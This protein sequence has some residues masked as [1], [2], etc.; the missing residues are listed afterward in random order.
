MEFQTA[1][2]KVALPRCDTCNGRFHPKTKVFCADCNCKIH[3]DCAVY[4]DDDA[5]DMLC[6]NCYKNKKIEKGLERDGI[7]MKVRGNDLCRAY[8]GRAYWSDDEDD[9]T[10]VPLGGTQVPLGKKIKIGEDCKEELEC[11]DCE[12]EHECDWDD[13]VCKFCGWRCEYEQSHIEYGNWK[14]DYIKDRYYLKLDDEGDIVW[15]PK[16]GFGYCKEDLYKR[17]CL[18]D[19]EKLWVCSDCEKIINDLKNK[20][21]KCGRHLGYCQ[22]DWRC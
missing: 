9:R 6:L 7:L 11:E 22:R 4:A 5:N 19:Y 21:E 8:I 15:K 18:A 17:G 16:C 2:C 13:D 3:Y 20:K 12:E 10:Q 1:P 14:C